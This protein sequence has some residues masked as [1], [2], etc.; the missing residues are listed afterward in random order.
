MTSNLLL[1]KKLGIISGGGSQPAALA[2]LCKLKQR[3]FFVLAIE[4]FADEAWVASLGNGQIKTFGQEENDT[5]NPLPRAVWVRLGSL[6]G[7][8]DHLSRAGVER[9]TYAGVVLN[10]SLAQ[11]WPDRQ[12]TCLLWRSGLYM[13][14][15]RFFKRARNASNETVQIEQSLVERILVSVIATFR[16]AGFELEGH[17]WIEKAIRDVIEPL[18]VVFWDFDPEFLSMFVNKSM[19]SIRQDK[20]DLNHSDLVEPNLTNSAT[21]TSQANVRGNEQSL[22]CAKGVVSEPVL[23]SPARRKRIT[24]TNRKRRVS[25]KRTRKSALS[26]SNEISSKSS[27][28]LLYNNTKQKKRKTSRGSD[29]ESRPPIAVS[30]QWDGTTFVLVAYGGMIALSCLVMMGFLIVRAAW[31]V[32]VGG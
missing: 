24:K 22:V 20:R 16:D 2:H 1:Q 5:L 8:L 12:F 7:A 13:T 3:D 17:A 29:N 19:C 32:V 25:S 10:P 23:D 27:P 6:G 15:A 31:L 30:W 21:A 14:A 4:G 18:G 11:L 9:V 28:Y 26:R